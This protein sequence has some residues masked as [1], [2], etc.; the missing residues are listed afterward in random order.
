[1]QYDEEHVR[2]FDAD[3]DKLRRLWT[4]YI[5]ERFDGQLGQHLPPALLKT[6]AQIFVNVMENLHMQEGGFAVSLE[7]ETIGAILATVFDFGQ[8]AVSAGVKTEDLTPC[9]CEFRLTEEDV[10]HLLNAKNN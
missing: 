4:E 5:H 8:Y 7:Q 10:A 6:C 2:L 3:S 1:M 9:T